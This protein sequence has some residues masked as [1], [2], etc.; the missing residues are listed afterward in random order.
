MNIEKLKKN[1]NDCVMLFMIT[2]F[3]LPRF[4]SDAV[5]VRAFC[6]LNEH[7]TAGKK[8]Y[9]WELRGIPVRIE[10]GF[11]DLKDNSV[12]VCI[13][14]SGEKRTI[15][16]SKLSEDIP[17]LLKE[18]HNEMLLKAKKTL[19]INTKLLFKWDDFVPALDNLHLCLVPWCQRVTCEEDIKTKSTRKVPHPT[20]P[21]MGAKSLCT[22]FRQPQAL[23]EGQRCINCDELAKSFTLF[24]RSY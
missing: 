24:G 4:T 16:L 8:F 13:R 19:D 9:H 11:R 5:G 10:V 7:V 17:N 14:F 22:P 12:I 18:I 2:F 23:D 21:S 6:D 20:H 1:I 3:H 15:K